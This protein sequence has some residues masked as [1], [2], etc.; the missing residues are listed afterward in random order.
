M[1]TLSP[2]FAFLVAVVAVAFAP[3]VIGAQGT[4]ARD[5]RPDSVAVVAVVEAFH[6]ALVRG[7]TAGVLELLAEDGRIMEGGGTETVEEYAA[8]H[9]PADIAFARAVT[10]ERGP[11]AVRVVGD[12]AWALSTSRTTGSYG[13]REIDS[14]GAELVVLSRGAAGWRIEAI[15]WSSR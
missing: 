7:D 2:T 4:S 3:P 12:V 9:L 10:R 11:V 5:K 1:R 15:H 14:R 13:G 8:H 6:D